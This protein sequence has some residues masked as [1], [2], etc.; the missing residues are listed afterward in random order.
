MACEGAILLGKIPVVN[1]VSC[2]PLLRRG[3][4]TIALLIAAT[5][6]SPA[7]RL[8]PA[9][10]RVVARAYAQSRV[11][12]DACAFSNPRDQSWILGNSR[13]QI[14]F[15]VTSARDFVVDEIRDPQSGHS[16][17]PAPEADS[18]VTV[19]GL[20]QSPGSADW[21]LTDIS[22]VQIPS[23]IKVGFTFRSTASGVAA[24]RWYMCYA[25]APAIEMWT[26]YQSIG[27]ASETISS[28]T[29]WRL[30]LPV[31]SFRY[32][33][34][35][36]QSSPDPIGAAS[37]ASQSATLQNSGQFTL[38]EPNRSTE[39]FLPAVAADAGA[40]AFFGGLMWSGSWQISAQHAG[41]L[42]RVVAGFPRLSTTINASRSL[43]TPHGFWGFTSGGSAGVA[44]SLRAFLIEGVRQGR[45]LEALVTYNT[46][47][48]YGT[49]IDD[50]TMRD[51]MT[52]AARLGVE[53]FVI[54]AG[55][56]VGA[57]N[58]ADFESGLGTWEIDPAKF[59]GGLADLRAHAQ[60]LGMRFG[61]WVEPERIDAATI[62]KP[63]LVRE[64]WLAKNNNNYVND[65]TPQ[66]CL[67]STDARQ[68]IFDRLTQLLDDVQPDYLKW[69]NNQWVNC[70]R[71]GHGHGAN[72]GNFSHV[73][74]LYDLLAALR[75]RY[76]KMLIENCSQGGNRLDFGM[77]RYTDSA[78]MDDRSFPASHVR[79]NVEGLIT[80]FPP[81]YLLSFAMSAIDEPLSGA[82]DLSL[83]M[84]SRMPGV[85]G[86]TY[87]S[88]DLTDNDDDAIAREIALYKRLRNLTGS[89]SGRL[90][91]DQ[92]TGDVPAWD[93]I[94][95]TD[96][97]SG[98]IVIFAFQNDEGVQ[99]VVVQ[100]EGLDRG[101]DYVVT[102]ADGTLVG[103][104]TGA[105]MMADGVTIYRSAES[106]AHVLVFEKQP[107]KP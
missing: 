67:A 46:W 61:L 1:F 14:Q 7:V 40:D 77:L 62:G 6:L 94:Q 104:G 64:E 4:L 80:F 41:N 43:E 98:G 85:L 27:G 21:P 45:Q 53:L 26:V 50:Q 74:G 93:V 18:V 33:H 91:T 30:A 106:A 101:A 23:G 79:H 99:G 96:S 24:V 83:Y 37:F 54:D 42:S 81:A 48:A 89:A 66:I 49:E 95:E 90:L 69:D 11:G 5:S 75:E 25:G 71:A 76:P 12:T 17:A 70:N 65:N 63:G 38:T 3:R 84:R 78:W 2:R 34:G 51:E 56:Y 36:R 44:E 68:W 29:V 82:L 59:P 57:G 92:V 15:R 16:M 52:A 28:P 86:L 100:P 72:D 73:A 10:P 103:S 13:L 97:A 35:L 8:T 107:V 19:N 22:T 31:T 39:T 102:G 88:S 47:F 58:G 9:L 105:Q 87:R 60:S 55:W 32:V 20:T